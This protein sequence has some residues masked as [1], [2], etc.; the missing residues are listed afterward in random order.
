MRP[1]VPLNPLK[2]SEEYKGKNPREMDTEELRM[3]LHI[4]RLQLKL[5]VE[6]FQKS[7]NYVKMIS[8]LFDSI[9]LTEKLHALYNKYTGKAEKIITPPVKK[10][11]PN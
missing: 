1:K 8:N 4:K 6:R 7:L 2:G 10:N 3:L 11:H 5:E 9:G